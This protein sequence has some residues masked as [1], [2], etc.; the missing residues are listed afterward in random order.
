MGTKGR[1][2]ALWL[3][4][5]LMLASIL[6]HAFSKVLFLAALP[7]VALFL[8][9][10]ARE[11]PKAVRRS[12]EMGLRMAVLIPVK[13][14]WARLL[15]RL[16]GER[17]GYFCAAY[18]VHVKSGTLPL[19]DYL[20]I[21]SSDLLIAAKMFPGALFIWETSAPLPLSIRRMV[22]SGRSVFLKNGG[23]PVP[24][25]PFTGRDLRKGHVK[26]GAVISGEELFC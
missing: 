18:E 8:R 25:F 17:M 4:F 14:S 22:R 24:R 23:W 15:L 12:G 16:D 6:V 9:Y 19:V 7:E 26:H 11:H 5:A 21:L 2:A 20:R 1:D 10:C 3:F 13:V